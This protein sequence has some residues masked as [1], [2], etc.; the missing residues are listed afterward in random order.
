MGSVRIGRSNYSWQ[1]QLPTG[2]FYNTAEYNGLYED[3]SR[4]SGKMGLG[5]KASGSCD[6]YGEYTEVNPLY[7]SVIYC[8]KFS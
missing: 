2:A 3:A 4:A 7:V 5:F 8:I 1:V 6:R